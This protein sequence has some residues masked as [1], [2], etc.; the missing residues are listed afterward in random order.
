MDGWITHLGPI[1]ILDCEAAGDDPLGW[2]LSAL[3]PSAALAWACCRC[4]DALLVHCRS[5]GDD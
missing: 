5:I 4:D 3:A 2:H 1:I